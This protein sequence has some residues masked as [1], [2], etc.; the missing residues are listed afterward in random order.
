MKIETNKFQDKFKN[1]HIFG[2]HPI[3]DWHRII[4]VSFLILSGVFIWSYFFYFS[5]Q[6]EFTSDFVDNSQTVPNK[7]KEAEIKDVV[8]KYKVKESAWVSTSTVR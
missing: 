7:D 6:S 2:S 8:D 1:I 5:V 3:Q 4:V